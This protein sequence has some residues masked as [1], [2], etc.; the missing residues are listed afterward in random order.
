MD[1]PG[2]VQG[3]IDT[4]HVRRV[5]CATRR[6]RR[7]P[8]RNM[9]QRTPQ[10]IQQMQ[11]KLLPSQTPGAIDLDFTGIFN[12]RE[13]REPPPPPPPP[14]A[15]KPRPVPRELMVGVRA[16]QKDS[17]YVNMTRP[18]PKRRIDPAKTT[19]LLVEDDNTTRNILNFILTRGEGYQTRLAGDVKGF[20]AALQK[21]PM[22][23][24]VILDVELPG[25][26][27][28][29]RMLQKIRAHPLIS[30]MPVIIFSGHS[31]PKDLQQGL[32]FGADAYL[33]KPARAEAITAA[34]KACD[35]REKTDPV[36]VRENADFLHWKGSNT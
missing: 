5:R 28:G 21:K 33:S 29:F 6:R 25:G 24:A 14:P 22:P 2:R 3:K 23:D 4:A 7:L 32:A 31:E 30:H 11:S 10:M 9:H 26:V 18:R 17:Y 20:V 1:W 13:L 19:V 16:L 12:L 8:V 35:R 15:A 34:V 36:R 27:N